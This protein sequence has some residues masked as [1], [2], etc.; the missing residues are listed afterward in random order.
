MKKLLNTL[1]V[2]LPDAYLALEGENVVVR[3]NEETRLRV[4]LH[5]LEGIV[6]FGYTGA[7][8][9]LMGAC[10]EKQIALTFLTANG[11]FLAGLVGQE[12]GNVVLR[13]TQYRHSDDEVLSAR[14][15][16]NILIGKLHN[17]RWVLERAVRDHAARLDTEKVRRAAHMIVEAISLLRE[18][19][20]LDEMR[21]IEGE[22]ATRYFSVFDEMILQ[23]KDAFFFHTRNRRPPLDNVNA[24]LSFTYTLLANDAASALSAVGL[25][26]FVGFLHRDRPGRRSLALDLIEELRAPVAD[27]FVL[28]LINMRQ[29]EGAGFYQKENG[30]VI[31]RDETRRALL[32]AWQNRKQEQI[33]HPF[34]KEKIEW[35]VVPHAQAQLLARYLRGD[36]DEY[37]PFLWK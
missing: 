17:S 35:G 8:P 28:T 34:L 27:R 5:N 25:D 33:V 37:P 32:T 14:I 16:K 1:Y 18:A 19:E 11:R 26:P 24:L 4:P 31:M 6:S 7:S 12:R 30:A 3:C 10:A 15:A 20:S 21:G 22:A 9:A 36:L 29:V 2:T 13:K 23:N